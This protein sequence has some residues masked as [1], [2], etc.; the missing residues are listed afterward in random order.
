M[1]VLFCVGLGAPWKQF[2]FPG[3][4]ARSSVSHWGCS[5]AGTSIVVWVFSYFLWQGLVQWQSC[6][7]S[8]SHNTPPGTTRW[9]KALWLHGLIWD[10]QFLHFLRDVE[11]AMIVTW[12]WCVDLG[13][14]TLNSATFWKT[15]GQNFPSNLYTSFLLYEKWVRV[16]FLNNM[17]DLHILEA[18]LIFI[19]IDLQ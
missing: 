5:K 17:N 15:L 10:V 16:L 9:K 19:P 14:R 7:I 4:H 1:E 18:L 2:L 11:L 12:S 8:T 3:K 13:I 6:C